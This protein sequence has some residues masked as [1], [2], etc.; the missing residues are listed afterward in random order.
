LTEIGGRAKK[1]KKKG[2]KK[3]KEGPL[4]PKPEN[5]FKTNRWPKKKKE[6]K[7]KI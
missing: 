2:A 3:E 4:G 5:K 6:P 7:G 1:Q